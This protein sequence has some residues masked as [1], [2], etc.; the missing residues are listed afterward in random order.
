MIKEVRLMLTISTN[1]VTNYS[2][3]P[4]WIK[5]ERYLY[6]DN[7]AQDFAGNRHA[8]FLAYIRKLFHK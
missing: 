6:C 3:T 2:H 4:L 8:S 1:F 5:S 7:F